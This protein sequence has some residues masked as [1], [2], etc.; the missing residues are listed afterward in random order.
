[1]Q[2]CFI[3]LYLNNKTKAQISYT[4]H[5]VYKTCRTF[6]ILAASHNSIFEPYQLRLY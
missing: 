4:F 5:N 2:L 6:F 3:A 1:M